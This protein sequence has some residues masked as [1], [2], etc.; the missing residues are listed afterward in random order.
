VDCDRL[1]KAEI[2][3]QCMREELEASKKTQVELC[4]S[5]VKAIGGLTLPR[6]GSWNKGHEIDLRS[7][8]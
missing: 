5:L 1:A 7:V 6:S 2:E 3:V 8:C 4:K